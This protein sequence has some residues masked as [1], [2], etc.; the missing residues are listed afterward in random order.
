MKKA[1]TRVQC[2]GERGER[3]REGGGLF[4][5]STPLATKTKAT[6]PSPSLC[7]PSIH[8]F[9]PNNVLQLL[10]RD[11]NE[12]QFCRSPR[13]Y[14]NRD[15]QFCISI[16]VMWKLIFCRSGRSTHATLLIESTIT[17]AAARGEGREG[18]QVAAAAMITAEMPPG[19][20]GKKSRRPS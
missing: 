3:R 12:D 16:L 5:S 19:E 2:H 13:A 7:F 10:M 17:T 6:L 11:Q 8:S 9:S 14:Q 4:L 1:E 15:E 18:K 20:M